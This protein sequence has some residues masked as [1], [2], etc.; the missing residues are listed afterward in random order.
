MKQDAF[1]I[2]WTPPR[3]KYSDVVCDCEHHTKPQRSDRLE[4][5][6]KTAVDLRKPNTF[7]IIWQVGS[8]SWRMVRPLLQG[9]KDDGAPGP[10]QKKTT[11]HRGVWKQ[12]R[13]LFAWSHQKRTERMWHGRL[14]SILLHLVTEMK[15]PTPLTTNSISKN[16]INKGNAQKFKQGK[17]RAEVCQQK[18]GECFLYYKWGRDSTLKVTKIERKGTQ[19]EQREGLPEGL[20]PRPGDGDSALGKVGNLHE[21]SR[22][23]IYQGKR[24]SVCACVW[25]ISLS[26]T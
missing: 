23:Q 8:L 6:S 15:T 22:R 12:H 14:M 21:C 4:Y 16:Q 20:V 9:K 19:L 25:W 26:F 18:K 17:S 24:V 11:R 1:H 3:T 7:D 5:S 13:L 2:Y 10:P